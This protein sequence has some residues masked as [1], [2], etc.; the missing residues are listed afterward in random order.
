MHFYYYYFFHVLKWEALQPHT[1][2]AA[3]GH[4]FTFTL[5]LKGY[6]EGVMP[7]VIITPFVRPAFHGSSWSKWKIQCVS[8]GVNS[9]STITINTIVHIQELVSAANVHN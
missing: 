8:E 2:D 9:P 4:C 6:S 1:M 3:H 5:K 7:P